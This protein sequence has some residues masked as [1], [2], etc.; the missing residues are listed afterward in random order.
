M[1]KG[2]HLN[3]LIMLMWKQ[4]LPGGAVKR[5]TDSSWVTGHGRLQ[6][7]NAHSSLSKVSDE[8]NTT[9]LFGLPCTCQRRLC[10]ISPDL[11]PYK[12]VTN[13]PQTSSR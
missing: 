2:F 3:A 9:R 4:V 7:E 12:A 11:C 1:L 10:P 6:D 8:N 13:W 5:V